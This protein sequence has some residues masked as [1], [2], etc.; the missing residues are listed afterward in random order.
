MARV[1]LVDDDTDQLEI[2]KLLVEQAGHQVQ[3]AENA[4]AAEAVCLAMAPQLVVMDLRLPRAEQGLG[5]IRALRRAAPGVRIVVLAGWPADL[6]ESPEAGMVDLLL[7][8]PVHT[9]RLLDAIGRLV[10]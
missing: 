9:R 3:V 4:A 8:K 5:L 7:P 6:S 2:R 1:L 10:A